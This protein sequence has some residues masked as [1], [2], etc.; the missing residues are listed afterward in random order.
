MPTS[1]KGLTIPGLVRRRKRDFSKRSF[2]V[3]LILD[4]GFVTWMISY[5]F[6][7]LSGYTKKPTVRPTCRPIIIFILHIKNK[8]F[9]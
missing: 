9:T 2:L 6:S 5:Y 3:T 7:I 4:K 8:N 1:R